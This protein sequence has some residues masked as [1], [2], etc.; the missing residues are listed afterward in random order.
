[1]VAADEYLQQARPPPPRKD[2][3][4]TSRMQP[5]IAERCRKVNE[6]L[7]QMGC[8]CWKHPWLFVFRLEANESRSLDHASR[9]GSLVRQ[10]I[11]E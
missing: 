7:D 5:I 6:H 10:V 1:M 9:L 2:L 4:A 8:V 3:T 11:H